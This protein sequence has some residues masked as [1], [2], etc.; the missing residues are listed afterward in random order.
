[1]SAEVLFTEEDKDFIAEMMNIGAGNAATALSQILQTSVELKIPMIHIAPPPK[2]SPLI[3]DPALAVSCVK[4]SMV[5]D[6]AGDLFFIVPDKHKAILIQKAKLAM[7]G[8]TEES[9]ETDSSVLKEI[10]NI[11]A[12]VYLTSIH[13]FCGLNI[14]HTVPALAEDML[15][16]LLDE[17]IVTKTRAIQSLLLV[18]NEFVV[19][20]EKVRTYFL[21]IPDAISLKAMADSI[22]EAKKKYGHK[23]D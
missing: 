8:S 7:P 20:K 6:I 3:G 17:T 9:P 11:I 23:E 5:G 15:L 19:V 13:D 18:E 22:G 16:A 21:I 1:M 2:I 14:Y 12:G 10:G 4:M